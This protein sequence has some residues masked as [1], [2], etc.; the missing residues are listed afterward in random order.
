MY[1]GFKN[2]FRVRPIGDIIEE[3]LYVRDHWG[4]K[5]FYFQDDIF[6]YDMKWLEEFV[7]R[8]RSEVAVPWHCQI[9]LEL[10]RGDA[11]L[12]RLRL[13]REG[14]ASGITLAI[15]SGD[16]FLREFVLLRPMTQELV[17]EG[18]KRIMEFGLTLRTEQILQV[19]FSNLE[20]DLA[21]LKLNNEINPQMAWSSILAPFG[22]TNMGKIAKRFGFYAG[23]NDDLDEEFYFDYSQLRHSETGRAA[24]EPL[25]RSMKAGRFESPLLRMHARP[26]NG[27]SDVA[28]V[29][30]DSSQPTTAGRE[31]D[32]LCELRYM[33]DEE[34]TRYCDQ[35]SRLQRLFNW[36]SKVPRGYRLGSA[37]VEL[38]RDTWTFANLG[39][40]TEEHLMAVG[41]GSK[42]EAWKRALASKLD[43]SVESLPRGIRDNPYYFCFF[44]S[45]HEFAARV[46]GKGLFDLEPWKFFDALGGEARRW[47]FSRYVY[48]TDGAELPIATQ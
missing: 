15:E 32:P 11:G 2:V 1:G 3:A 38:N 26:R 9:R 37:W 34:N 25:V 36:L 16:A 30:M 10:A 6:G 28:D 13:F 20:T 42:L 44:P 39:K 18:C 31:A 17:I 22:E 4:A 14:L 7:R 21:T 46:A 23:N 47:L 48:K 35:T 33:S 5:M 19:P 41:Y 8:W 40:L 27:N 12:E 29:F 24:V 43:V 45:G